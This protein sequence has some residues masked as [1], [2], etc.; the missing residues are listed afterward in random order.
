MADLHEFIEQVRDAN[1][2]E[3]VIQSKEFGAVTLDRRGHLWSGTHHDSLKVSIT[4]Q[5]YFWYSQESKDKYWKGDVFAWVQRERGCDFMDAVRIL[6]ER[7]GLRMPQLEEGDRVKLQAFRIM[8]D[9]YDVANKLFVEWLWK[10]EGALAYARSRGWT[11]ETIREANLGFT[12]RGTDA[13]Y[14]QMKKALAPTIDLHEPAAVALLGLKGG[15][16]AWG[17]RRGID[18]SKWTEK[19]RIPSFLGWSNIFGLVYPFFEHGK[20]VYFTR[21]NLKV[22]EDGWLVSSDEPKSYNLP[23]ELAGARK[24][25]RNAV[26]S[27]HSQRGI[28]VEGPACAVTFL[29]WE[30]QRKAAL[31]KYRDEKK[32]VPTWL[33]DMPEMAATAIVGKEWKGFAEAIGRETNLEE[34]H[35]ASFIGLDNDQAGKASIKGERGN[36]WAIVEKIGAMTRLLECPE[37]DFNDWLKWM[38]KSDAELLNSSE[39]EERWKAIEGQ[40]YLVN[41][42]LGMAKPFAVH[43]VRWMGEQKTDDQLKKASERAARIVNMLGASEIQF[44]MKDFLEALKPL[45]TQFRGKREVDQWLGKDRKENGQKKKE[46]EDNV[47]YSL[48][49]KRGKWLLEYCYRPW[50]SKVV[51]AYRDPDGN[52]EEADEV[53]IDGLIERPQ[54]PTDKMIV[55]G[56][57]LF[58]TGLARKKDGSVWRMTTRELVIETTK[59]LRKDYLFADHKWPMLC[60]YWIGGTWAYDM[61]HELVYLR[62]VGDAGA[63]KS[64]LLNLLGQ[65]AY[66]SIKMSGADS[67]STFFRVVD[68]YRGT[69]M[70]EEADLPENSGPENPIVKFVNLGAF[71]GNFI[72]RMEE[73]IKPDGTKGWRPTPFRT[74]CPKMFAMRGEFMDNAVASRAISV[75]LTAAES[76]TMKENNIPWR[77]TDEIRRRLL[78]LRNLWLTWRLYEYT[79]E[80][81]ELDWDLIDVDIPMRNN[82]V[83]VPLKS[84]AKNLDGTKDEEFLNQMQVLL[85]EHYQD[86]IGD[87]AI[88]W[89]ARVAEAMWKIYIYPDL[90]ERIDIREDGSMLIKVGDVTAIANNI[91][92]EMNE[93]GSDLR[94]EKVETRKVT[95]ADGS[96]ETVEQKRHKK[97]F[98]KGAQAIG[99]ILK[100]DFQLEFP[101][102]S[103]KGYRA[104]W[105]DAKMLAIGKKYGCLPPMEKIEEARQVLAARRGG[106]G[107]R[108]GSVPFE[109]VD[110]KSLDQQENPAA[111]AL[112]L[113]LPWE[114]E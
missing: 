70:F 68:E 25:Y 40:L 28:F 71:D 17:E 41:Q 8:Q 11:D 111:E 54:P 64:A 74:Y 47:V 85:R 32:E 95:K 10:D 101:P 20:V 107:L 80:E 7:A 14:E 77:L 61:F 59:E 52:V 3:D 94:V 30:L 48:G 75:K 23:K 112:E 97:D 36:E 99:R 79:T 67:E 82:Q 27:K 31:R 37:K 83:T 84:L 2:I 98:E 15:V 69:I 16:G 110:A 66:R 86:Q 43:A 104:K 58:P 4:H 22:G 46:D 92:D 18:V 34:G 39:P 51:W 100:N 35:D 88:S 81:R 91:A 13:E 96:T 109:D 24:M 12:G 72:Y 6:A 57:A 33:A 26:W 9:A 65:M 56:A 45:G 42:Q 21:R 89:Q 50:E 78:H 1:P 114:S 49:G 103:G 90:H 53:M 102:R 105:D 113:D 63:G 5:N 73:F 108:A 93:E 87:N 76:R 106:K 29:Q 44:Y 38:A 60:A 55:E 19:D 62:M